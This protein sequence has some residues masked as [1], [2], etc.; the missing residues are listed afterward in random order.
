MR[1]PV[2]AGGDSGA[3]VAVGTP[4]NSQVVL[5]KCGCGG[6]R[7]GRRNGV[8]TT[9]ITAFRQKEKAKTQLHGRFVPP[10]ASDDDRA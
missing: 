4:P 1:V 2:P 7:G 9:N 5:M 8:Y 10:K 6:S 3:V